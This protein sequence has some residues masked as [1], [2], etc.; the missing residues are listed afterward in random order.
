MK[1]FAVSQKIYSYLVKAYQWYLRTQQR[2][3]DEAYKAAL[4]IKAIEDEHFDGK[5]IA[6][7][8]KSPS[9]FTH[10]RSSLC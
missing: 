2:S 8:Q 1:D 9:G 3:L 7:H 4:Q 6:S 5:K 10:G